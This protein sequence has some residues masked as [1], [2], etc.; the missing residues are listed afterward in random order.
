V[1]FNQILSISGQHLGSSIL[2]PAMRSIFFL[3]FTSALLSGCLTSQENPNYQHS[4]LYKAI[5]IE[6]TQYASAEPATVTAA[7]YEQT[8]PSQLVGAQTTVIQPTPVQSMPAQTTLASI[9]ASVTAPT[10]TSYASREVSGTPGFMAMESARQASLLEAASQDLPEA[11]LVRS[12]PLVAMGTPISY[13]Y[14]R[15]LVQIDAT[16][17][18]PQFSEVVR[19]MPQVS[20][21]SYTVQ[22]GDTVYSLA[23]KSCVGVSVIQSMNGLNANYAIKIGQSLTLP[24]SVC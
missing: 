11:E 7:S 10:D 1:I 2:G 15:N 18:E 17:S 19:A 20:G 14:S 24:A 16:M 22:Q 3:S 6:Q 21:Y 5:D 4:T 9:P 8:S 13:D 23:R 12:A